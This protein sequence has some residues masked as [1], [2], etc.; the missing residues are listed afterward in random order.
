MFRT[1]VLDA[2]EDTSDGCVLRGEK[3]RRSILPGPPCP[4]APLC[5]ARPEPPLVCP[6]FRIE[7]F[8]LN[9]ISLVRASGETFRRR[10]VDAVESKTDPCLL[11][12]QFCWHLVLLDPAVRP[13]VRPD[14]ARL[15]CV[16]VLDSTGLDKISFVRASRESFR[17]R[18]DDAF[19]G[20][21]DACL[22]IDP[23]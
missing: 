18:F 20:T 21:R 3:F 19:E 23:W 13:A 4:A 10:F 1:V 8:G 9:K 2:L 16:R 15:R 6:G 12:Q 22:E 14:L 5:A 11:G 17:R 7:R